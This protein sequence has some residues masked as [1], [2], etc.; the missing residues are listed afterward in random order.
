MSEFLGRERQ[1]RHSDRW[2]SRGPD[3]IED[4]WIVVNTHHHGASR[5]DA[6]WAGLGTAEIL[7][8]ALDACDTQSDPIE[9]TTLPRYDTQIHTVTLNYYSTSNIQSIESFAGRPSYPDSRPG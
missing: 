7:R 9:P 6:R 3:P 4:G 1:V 8:D 5:G 2:A